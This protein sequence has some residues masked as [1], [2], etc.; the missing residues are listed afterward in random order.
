MAVAEACGAMSHVYR[1]EALV[2]D[3]YR[4][5]RC[6]IYTGMTNGGRIQG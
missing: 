2:S 3:L 6:R 1:E 5:D 4:D